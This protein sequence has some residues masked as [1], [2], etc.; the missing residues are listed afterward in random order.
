MIIVRGNPNAAP[1]VCIKCCH[2]SIN[3]QSDRCYKCHHQKEAA[4]EEEKEEELDDDDEDED[5]DLVENVE[6][7]CQN[8]HSKK[9]PKEPDRCKKCKYLKPTKFIKWKPSTDWIVFMFTNEIGK[10]LNV[11]TPIVIY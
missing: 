8:C 4:K 1:C 11:Y 7:R 3:H 10:K 5:D 6:W 2:Q 9:H